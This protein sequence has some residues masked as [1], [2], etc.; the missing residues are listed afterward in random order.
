MEG[1]AHGGGGA[2][3]AGVQYQASLRPM[4]ATPDGGAQAALKAGVIAAFVPFGFSEED[5]AEAHKRGSGA[6]GWLAAKAAREG[7]ALPNDFAGTRSA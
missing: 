4:M 5:A 1:A 2:G 6:A 3:A 7:R